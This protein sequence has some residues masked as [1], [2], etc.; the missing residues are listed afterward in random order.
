[1]AQIVVVGTGGMG[2]E[3]AAWLVDVGRSDDL[4]GFLDDDHG[5]HG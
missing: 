2:R 3:A 1:M 4:A 5:R